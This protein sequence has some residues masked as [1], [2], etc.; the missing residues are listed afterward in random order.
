MVGADRAVVLRAA[1]LEA[2]VPSRLAEMAGHVKPRCQRQGWGLRL[3][4]Q[5]CTSIYGLTI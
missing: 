3:A 2:A 5:L 1:M 4:S